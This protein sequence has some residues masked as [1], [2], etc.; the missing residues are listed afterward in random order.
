MHSEVSPILRV[1]VGTPVYSWDNHKI[2]KVKEIQSDA[3]KVETGLLQRD[4]WLPAA[5][6]NEAV[7]DEAVILSFEKGQLDTHKVAEPPV[8]EDQ[9]AA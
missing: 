2:G 4:Y 3:F 7:P 5:S 6:I 1:T 9:H 8:I